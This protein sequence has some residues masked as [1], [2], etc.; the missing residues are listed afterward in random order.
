MSHIYETCD[1]DMKL[2]IGARASVKAAL[3][4]A[5]KQNLPGSE[6]YIA[7][8]DQIQSDLKIVVNTEASRQIDAGQLKLSN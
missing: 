8:L 6:S 3:R 2:V 5:K 1:L 7:K 4:L